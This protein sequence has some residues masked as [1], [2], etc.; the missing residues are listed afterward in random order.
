MKSS[1]RSDIWPQDRYD[2]RAKDPLTGIAFSSVTELA[3][4]D[5]T[6]AL[7]AAGHGWF[8]ER[9]S[10]AYSCHARAAV[11]RPVTRQRRLVEPPLLWAR[12]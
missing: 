1:L 2:A 5:S 3:D 11:C 8:S 12:W 4:T 9:C 10:T 6:N 7:S